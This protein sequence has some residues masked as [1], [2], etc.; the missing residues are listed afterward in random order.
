MSPKNK[1]KAS[2]QEF[3]IEKFN[4]YNKKNVNINDIEVPD[5]VFLGLIEGIISG[6]FKTLPKR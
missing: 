3:K 1:D 4:L 5:H 6:P 2:T